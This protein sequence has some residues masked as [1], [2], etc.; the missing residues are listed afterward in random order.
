M[1]DELFPVQ[2]VEGLNEGAELSDINSLVI[3]GYSGVGIQYTPS[4]S[5]SL[6]KLETILTFGN[7]L[8]GAEIKICIYSDYKDKPSDIQLSSGSFVPKK[9]YGEWRIVTLNPISIIKGR[10]YWI[11]IHPNGYAVA[12]VIPKTG[13]N[14]ILSFKKFKKWEAL[15]EYAEGGKV[16]FKFYGRILPV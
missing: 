1:L 11:T 16:M 12:F 4:L 2:F 10:R 9:V 14:S 15:P 8:D 5:Y 3:T 13:Q 6:T 7:S